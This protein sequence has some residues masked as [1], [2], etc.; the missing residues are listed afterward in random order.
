MFYLV[1]AT[2]VGTGAFGGCAGHLLYGGTWNREVV[3]HI[4]LGICASLMVPLFLNTISSTL[5]QEILNGAALDS[6]KYLILIGFCLIASMS[7]QKFIRLMSANVIKE[8]KEVK[9]QAEDA[10]LKAVSAL[11]V[12]E[13]SMEPEAGTFSDDDKKAL[14]KL[15]PTTNKVLIHLLD[16]PYTMR[17]ASGLAQELELTSETV[18]K[19]LEGLHQITFVRRGVNAKNQPRWYLTGS[20]KKAAIELRKS[21][22]AT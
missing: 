1:L 10:Q 8:L 5:L 12:A 2:L 17:S 16:G 18:N 9:E 19:I 7:S 4:I 6:L 11:E 22:P 21:L 14:N 15:E 13:R 20:G 3:K